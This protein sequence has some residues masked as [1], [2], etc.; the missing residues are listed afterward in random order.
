MAETTTPEPAVSAAKAAKPSAAPVSAIT[1]AD[2]VARE[3]RLRNRAEMTRALVGAA[4]RAGLQRAVP[5]EFSALLAR[6]EQTGA[7]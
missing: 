2:F 5:A 4:E 6:L 1:L 7:R 3:P